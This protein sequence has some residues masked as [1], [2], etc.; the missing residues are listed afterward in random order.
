MKTKF[1]N[2]YNEELGS[3]IKEGMKAKKLSLD[4]LS[5]EL[6]SKLGVEIPRSSLARYVTGENTITD[7]RYEAVCKVL[8]INSEEGR[9]RAVSAMLSEQQLLAASEYFTSEEWHKSRPLNEHD[10]D[11]RTITPDEVLMVG[12]YRDASDKDK[13][14]VRTVLGM[15]DDGKE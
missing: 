7:D 4:N 15:K 1:S 6:K 3:F 2:A 12:Y 5:T 9:A 8:G 14:V 11:P 10:I 13:K